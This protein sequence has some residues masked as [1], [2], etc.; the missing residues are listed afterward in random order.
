M[1]VLKFEKPG[2]YMCARCCEFTDSPQER[3]HVVVDADEWMPTF[4]LHVSV[5]F[6]TDQCR[7]EFHDVGAA[8]VYTLTP[9]EPTDAGSRGVVTY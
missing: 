1:S 9:E 8:G 7:Q 6:C 5:S 3:L 2:K 4:H